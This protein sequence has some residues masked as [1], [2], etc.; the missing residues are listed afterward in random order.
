MGSAL[1]WSAVLQGSKEAGSCLTGAAVHVRC[2]QLHLHQADLQAEHVASILRICRW[3]GYQRPG[4]VQ[5]CQ[6][7]QRF[8]AVRC[9]AEMVRCDA[10]Q[11][12]PGPVGFTQLLACC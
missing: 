11:L 6:H 12:S 4:R 9:H 10:L 5:T 7:L 8:G 1:T 3:V 2:G